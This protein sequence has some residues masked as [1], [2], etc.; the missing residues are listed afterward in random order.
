[1]EGFLPDADVAFLDEV[2]KANSSILN[3]LLTLLNERV[4]DNGRSRIEAPLR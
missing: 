1:M 3:A 4:F 2:F